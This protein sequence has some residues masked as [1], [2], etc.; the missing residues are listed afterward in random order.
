MKLVFYAHSKAT[1]ATAIDEDVAFLT[2]HLGASLNGGCEVKS[3]RDDHAARFRAAGS[4]A[5]WCR[6]VARR[7]DVFV[8]PPGPI[9]K[10]TKDI[11]IDALSQDKA[12]L[13][14]NGSHNTPAFARA[15]SVATTDSENWK[16]GWSLVLR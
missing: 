2:K 6:Q 8:V 14:W 9:G 12:V 4:W 7:Y 1:L 3:G 15:A 5:D 16:A 13:S 10:A 11:L